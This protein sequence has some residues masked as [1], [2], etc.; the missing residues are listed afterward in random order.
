MLTEC[1]SKIIFNNMTFIVMIKYSKAVSK[2]ECH[3]IVEQFFLRFY[4][5]MLLQNVFDQT[6]EH[7]VINLALKSFFSSFFLLLLSLSF[8]FGISLFLFLLTLLPLCFQFLSFL[9]SFGLS[10]L[11]SLS[12][13]SLFHILSDKIFVAV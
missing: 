8:S 6:K 4:K 3:V 9:L 13:S 5:F 11:S 10:F 7:I 1:L 12:I 2:T